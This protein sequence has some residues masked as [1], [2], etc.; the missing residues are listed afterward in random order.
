MNEKSMMGVVAA[1]REK[2]E[3]YQKSTEKYDRAL[4]KAAKA[5]SQSL[6]L[7]LKGR[8]TVWEGPCR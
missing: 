2:L 4:V 6:S 7:F 1:E 3:N 5:Y 8:M